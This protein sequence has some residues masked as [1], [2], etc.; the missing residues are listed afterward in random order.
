MERKQLRKSDKKKN[1]TIKEIQKR[2]GKK[3]EKEKG[4][5]L[6][7][8]K[9]SLGSGRFI[10]RGKKSKSEWEGNNSIGSV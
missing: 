7:G 6:G 4:R 8:R 1:R 10:E 3:K 5:V 9:K 2:K